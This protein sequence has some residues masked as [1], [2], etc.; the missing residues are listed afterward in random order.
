V[1]ALAAARQMW[2]EGT[3]A[4]ALAALAPQLSG[5]L[6][7]QG[8]AAARAIG[9]EGHQARALAAFVREDD[10]M[11]PAIPH[12][13][14]ALVDHFHRN[15]S[16]QRRSDLLGFCAD[17]DLF[18]PP[19][20]SP[21]TLAAIA[22]HI[23]DICRWEWLSPAVL[24]L[25]IAQHPIQLRQFPAHQ[26]IPPPGSP[27]TWIAPRRG[28]RPFA[29]TS[30]SRIQSPSTSAGER[31]WGLSTPSADLPGRCGAPPWL[32]ARYPSSSASRG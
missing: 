15:L 31:S 4:A 8:L 29:P 28:E 2:D 19:I 23:I 14:R 6:L 18:R 9:D 25:L 11:S 22:D 20:L 7:A 5:A 1:D 12:I 13:R 21:A 3:R 24:R 17:K 32:C 30:H 26:P 10:E 27:A 16:Q